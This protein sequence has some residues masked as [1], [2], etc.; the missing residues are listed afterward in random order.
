[1]T[2]SVRGLRRSGSTLHWGVDGPDE[3]IRTVPGVRLLCAVAVFDTDTF[4]QAP[5]LNRTVGRLMSLV[6]TL[7]KMQQFH[8]Y[9]F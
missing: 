1:V 7:A 6:P 3:I 4:A 8:R 9:A 2:Q 5:R